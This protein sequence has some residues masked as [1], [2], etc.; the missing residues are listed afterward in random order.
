MRDLFKGFFVVFFVFVSSEILQAQLSKNH[1]IPPIAS[2]GR[3]GNNAYPQSQFI[4]ISTPSAIDVN[5]TVIPVGSSAASY[6]TGV[7]S[8]SAYAEI[9]VGSGDTNFAIQL[10]DGDAEAAAVLND[11]GYVI[12]ADRPVYVSVRLRAGGAQAGALV[13]KGSAGLGKSFRSGSFDS[14]SPQSNNYLYFV[15][16]VQHFTTLHHILKSIQDMGRIGNN[17]E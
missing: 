14:Q 17:R 3:S 9:S 8:K 11:K 5:Y 12:N 2:N 1:Y 4:Y 10:T 15:L 6:I 13:S 7:V 16:R